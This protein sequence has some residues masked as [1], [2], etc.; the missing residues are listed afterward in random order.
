[1]ELETTKI[2]DIFSNESLNTV[3]YK[4]E[5]KSLGVQNKPRKGLKPAKTLYIYNLNK[6]INLEAVKNLFET[7]APV[8]S[9]EYSEDNKSSGFVHF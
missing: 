1:M 4:K 2:S 7:F 3:V 5:N 9:I 6:M 8:E